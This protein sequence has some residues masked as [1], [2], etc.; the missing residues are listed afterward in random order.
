L[1]RLSQAQDIQETVRQ[2]VDCLSDMADV[3]RSQRQLSDIDDNRPKLAQARDALSSALQ[4][5]DEAAKGFVTEVSA[6]IQVL[7][8]A[9]GVF[10]VVFEATHSECGLETVRQPHPSDLRHP[11]TPSR[12][13]SA[14]AIS[15]WR[16]TPPR[17][18][19]CAA[20]RPTAALRR[21]P[22]CWPGPTSPTKPAPT[23]APCWRRPGPA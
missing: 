7:G 16:R 10:A 2:A 1:R 4:L 8:M 5:I 17:T 13:T 12:R 15:W 6:H 21:W 20:S 18:Y 14:T 22:A 3:R 23:P 9:G 11:R 19:G